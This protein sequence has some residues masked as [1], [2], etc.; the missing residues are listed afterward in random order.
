MILA[1]GEVSPATL[2][3]LILLPSIPVSLLLSSVALV[4]AFSAQRTHS[5]ARS[6]AAGSLALSCANG[7]MIALS[8]L[9]SH[10]QI[11]A[12]VFGIMYLAIAAVAF[13]CSGAACA[14]V[15]SLQPPGE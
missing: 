14:R 1:Q 4:R 6:L 13:L 12:G 15:F 7:A 10:A 2:F 9:D 11:N 5:S 8:L 3:L